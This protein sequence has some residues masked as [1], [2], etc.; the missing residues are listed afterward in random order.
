[1]AAEEVSYILQAIYCE[2][3]IFA[4]SCVVGVGQTPKLAAMMPFVSKVC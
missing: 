4:L 1:M 3:L 2:N